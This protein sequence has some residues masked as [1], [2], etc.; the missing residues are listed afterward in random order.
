MLAEKALEIFENVSGDSVSTCPKGCITQESERD[1]G[2][3]N[4]FTED[5][6][7]ISPESPIGRKPCI[8]GKM[9]LAILQVLI[10]QSTAIAAGIEMDAFRK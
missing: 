9:C 8:S 5:V 4:D 6:S 1:E 2:K 10:L 3:P 7:N